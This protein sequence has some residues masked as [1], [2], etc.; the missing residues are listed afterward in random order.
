MR[1]SLTA[2]TLVASVALALTAPAYTAELSRGYQWVRAHPFTINAVCEW[3]MSLDAYKEAGF[4]SYLSHVNERYYPQIFDEVKRPKMDWHALVGSA[5][6]MEWYTTHVPQWCKEQ[7]GNAGWIVGDEWPLSKMSE[8]GA[9]GDAVRKLAPDALV[10]TAC[11]GMDYQI[12]GK[13]YTLETYSAYLDEVIEKGR[14]DV[15]HYDLYPFY[16][17]GT[18]TTMF[19]TMAVVREKSLAA[20]VPF[21]AW[22][23]SHGWTEGPFQEPSESE[24]RF[25]AF[26]HLAY[27]FTGLSY[28]TYAS[29]YQPY[30][31]AILDGNGKKT[32][33]YESV[34]RLVPEI[35]PLGKVLRFLRSTAVYY[36]P[37]R[38]LHRGQWLHPQPRGTVPWSPDADPRTKE[39]TV[40]DGPHG[41][42][43]GFFTDD[44]GDDYLMLV[45]CG[46]GA[47]KDAL[48]TSGA[49]SI[50]FGFQ[51]TA[52]ERLNRFSGKTEILHLSNHQLNHYVLPGGTG[53]LLRF[54]SELPWPGLEEEP[55]VSE[56]SSSLAVKDSQ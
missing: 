49:I 24:L 40:S 33:M 37:G 3:P 47:G 44:A 4:N 11:R 32:H 38:V 21:W 56:N 18:A 22:L 6:N 15:I 26:A 54:P 50:Q 34:A 30:S 7:P 9:L 27:G 55:L 19:Q 48:S 23:Q 41:F 20:G 51:V 16:R 53:D 39:V 45:N 43:L 35:K 25:Q 5:D 1:R 12:D 28:W 14:P 8:L 13:A 2:S 17:G 29:S 46:H 42:L 31:Q 52:L 10:Y 36:H